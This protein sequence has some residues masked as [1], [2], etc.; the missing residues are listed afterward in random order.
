MIE[1]V[2]TPELI[3]ALG[4]LW[5]EGLSTAEIGRRLGV[6]KNSVV[7]KAHRLSLTPRPSP[8]KF[9]ERPREKLPPKYLDM[10]GPSCSWPIGHPGDKDFHFC[11]ASATVGKPYC[12]DHAAVAYVRP[13]SS[14]AS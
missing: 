14:S 5:S 9:V 7:G 8:L 11:G 1:S 2:W 6:T 10:G 3:D 4:K 12:A 13:K